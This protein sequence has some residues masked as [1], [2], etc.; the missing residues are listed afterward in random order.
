MNSQVLDSVKMKCAMTV[1]S[2]C[3][4]RRGL[5]FRERWLSIFYTFLFFCSDIFFFS[6][7]LSLSLSCFLIDGKFLMQSISVIFILIC[8]VGKQS[9]ILSC[10]LMPVAAEAIVHKFSSL[11]FF[12]PPF[13][14]Q[15]G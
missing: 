12:F 3:P 1:L 8:V 7:L 10:F 15:L 11:S 9:G 14:N 6:Y 2:L 4:G 5:S 13:K